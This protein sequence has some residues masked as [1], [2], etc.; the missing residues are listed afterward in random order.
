VLNALLAPGPR[1]W[2][3]LPTR[4]ELADAGGGIHEGALAAMVDAAGG[5]ATWS[6]DGFDPR[7][8]PPP[9]ACTS[10]S[11]AS[12]PARTSSSSAH[13][14]ACG[15]HLLTTVMLTARTTGH[16]VRDRIGD[17]PHRPTGS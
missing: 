11:T 6:V 10:A 2:L 13:V 12:R 17:V 5:A 1:P 14:V 7:G 9:S 8:A 16:P 3:V 15:R 4:P